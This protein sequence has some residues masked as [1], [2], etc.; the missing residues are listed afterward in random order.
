MGPESRLR[1]QLVGVALVNL[2]TLTWATNMTLGR[3][4]RADV[5]PLT[6]AA[7]RFTIATPVFVLLYRRRRELPVQRRK[8]SWLIAG[9]A[10]IGV[11]LFGPTLYLGLRYTPAVTAT[12]ING[13]GPLITGLL[14]AFLIREPMSR[15]Q[16]GGAV[17]GLVG[18]TVLIS[19]GSLAVWEG[20]GTN[21]GALIVLAAITLWGLY[22]VLGR[23]VMR[24]RSAL[25]ATAVTTWVGVP[26]LLMAAAWEV[27]R[28]PPDLTPRVLLAIGYIGLVPTVLGFLAWNAGVR[29]LGASGAMVFYN[30]LPL[31]GT[32]LGV[33]LLGETVGLPH[34][35]GGG[36]IIGGGLWAAWKGQSERGSSVRADAD[37]APD[38]RRE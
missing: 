34:L 6:L 28:S 31:Y 23:Q 16:L 22:S 8:D 10:L 12:L 38:A 35:I 5:G 21:A 20:V 32:L 36:L 24:T 3:W 15:P 4:L 29:R 11:V 9:M 18:V 1:A 17:L 7:A 25:S 27:H 37:G 2:A 26:F 30:S 14:A 33:I 19:G 13:L